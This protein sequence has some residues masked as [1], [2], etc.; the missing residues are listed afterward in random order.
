MGS[1]EVTG[2]P[3]RGALLVSLVLAVGSGLAILFVIKP[4]VDDRGEPVAPV[5]GGLFL[6]A[7]EVLTDGPIRTSD[8]SMLDAHGGAVLAWAL[9]PAVIAIGAF[10]IYQFRR[11]RGL[12]L[13]WP[14]TVSMVLLALSV[15]MGASYAMPAMV[16]MAIASFQVRKAE[17][18]ARMAGRV[19]Q[20]DEAAAEDDDEDEYYD[21]DE[22]EDEDEYDDED[23]EVIE[24]DG[25]DTTDADESTDDLDDTPDVVSADDDDDD[26]DPLAA[27]EEEIAAE[28]EADGKNKGR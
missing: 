11:P 23:D 17:M 24:V 15:M 26:V 12:S 6:R 9:L 3:G 10:L 7:R 22:Y 14:L 13:Y 19:A 16:A 18:P 1:V 2:N 5:F 20:Q 21:E 27:L 25:E 8:T 28:D 4:K